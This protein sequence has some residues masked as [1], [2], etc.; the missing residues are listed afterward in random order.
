M[1]NNTFRQKHYLKNSFTFLFTKI[2]NY[3]INQTIFEKEFDKL[4]YINQIKYRNSFFYLI[5][6]LF[7]SFPPYFNQQIILY[8][9]KKKPTKKKLWKTNKLLTDLKEKPYDFIQFLKQKNK[10]TIQS[11]KF[12]KNDLFRMIKSN[13]FE[14]I[15]Y[16]LENQN[17]N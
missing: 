13:N 15:L 11:L 8:L 5:N 16:F 2:P 3:I 17:K 4:K 12:Q 10:W 9:E 14:E 6:F 7:P 1:E